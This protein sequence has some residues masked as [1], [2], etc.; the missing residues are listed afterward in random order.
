MLDNDTDD[1]EK[2]FWWGEKPWTAAT[3]IDI[4]IANFFMMMVY[5]VNGFALI[6]PLL[7]EDGCMEQKIHPTGTWDQSLT[8]YFCRNEFVSLLRLAIR[9][10]DG[11]HMTWRLVIGGKLTDVRRRLSTATQFRC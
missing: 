5:E 4:A 3:R 6:V 7:A 2:K 10:R 8:S 11:E 9:P 1:A